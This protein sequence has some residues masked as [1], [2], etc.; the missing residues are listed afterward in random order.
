MKKIHEHLCMFRNKTVENKIKHNSENYTNIALYT[1]NQKVEI[2]KKTHE[3]IPP[4]NLIKN[5][6]RRNP[7]LSEI[8]IK[9]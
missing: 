3:Y 5:I 2:K 7:N 9:P 4:K 1:S 8:R 6:S